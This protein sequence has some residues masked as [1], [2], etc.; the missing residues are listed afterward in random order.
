MTNTCKG[1]VGLS[2]QGKEKAIE[3]EKTAQK[4]LKRRDF[5]DSAKNIAQTAHNAGAAAAKNAGITGMTM[6]G[7]MNL[8]AVIRGEKSAKDAITDMVVDTGKA[9]ATGYV[10]GGGRTAVSHALSGSSSEFLRALSKSNVPGK[11]ITGVILTG[12]TLKRYGNG[13]ISTQE[14]FIE[15]GEQGLNFATTGY[16]MAVGQAL[17]PIPVVGAAVG[18]LVGSMV[19][20]HYYNQLITTLQRKEI[21]HQERL[22]I[23]AECKQAAQQARA[24]REELE[25]YLQSYFKEYQ[26]CFDDALATIRTSYQIGDA[27]GVIAGANQITRKLGGKVYYDNMNEFKDFLFDDSTDIL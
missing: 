6:S 20:S 23:I 19:T 10:M 3:S 24:F 8:T 13:E 9:A 27:D 7:I 26:D 17:I 16:S 18:A 12:N 4:I 5:Q 14:C 15:L 1:G 22:R 11:V 21:E 2:E 25:S